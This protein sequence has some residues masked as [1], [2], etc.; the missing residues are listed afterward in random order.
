MTTYMHSNNDVRVGT[1]KE[2]G[3]EYNFLLNIDKC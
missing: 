1:G 2:K 3:T